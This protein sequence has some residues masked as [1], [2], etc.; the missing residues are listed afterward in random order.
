MDTTGKEQNPAEVPMARNS[1]QRS[2]VWEHFTPFTAGDGKSKADCKKCKRVLAA[3][4]RNGTSSLRRHVRMCKRLCGSETDRHESNQLTAG[5]SSVRARWA[6]SSASSPSFPS[7]LPPTPQQQQQPLLPPAPPLADPS[8]P[9]GHGSSDRGA[10]GLETAD[11]G[12]ARPPQPM[13]PTTTL[14]LSLPGSSM[15]DQDEEEVQKMVSG[16]EQLLCN[17]SI[18]NVQDNTGAAPIRS[19]QEAAAMSVLVGAAPPP[20]PSPCA[21]SHS[22]PAGG[23]SSR[24]LT[25]RSCCPGRNLQPTPRTT[26]RCTVSVSGTRP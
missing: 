2:N 23:G 3:E 19:V 25:S 24:G 14:S 22:V 13:L 6:R 16:F 7:D 12:A 10:S 26:N 5:I 11:V 15:N 1:S 17:T 18:H 4:T 20:P 21:P 9:H 8:R